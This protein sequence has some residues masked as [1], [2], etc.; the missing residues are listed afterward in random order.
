MLPNHVKIHPDGPAD[1][2]YFSYF[3]RGN[4]TIKGDGKIDYDVIGIFTSGHCHSFALEMHRVTGWTMVA[5][6]LLDESIYGPVGEYP[7]HIMVQHPNGKYV[8]IHGFREPRIDYPMVRRMVPVTKEQIMKFKGYMRPNTK[9][10]ESYVKTVL[11]KIGWT[12]DQKLF[13]IIAERNPAALGV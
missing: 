8:D 5:V 13:D 7:S 10:A 6:E 1:V 9:I 2:E 4:Q 3:G 11:R 12:G